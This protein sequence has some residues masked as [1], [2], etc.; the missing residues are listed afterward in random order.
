MLEPLSPATINQHFA[1]IRELVNE[2]GN[3]E[4]ISARVVSDVLRIKTTLGRFGRRGMSVNLIHRTVRGYVIDYHSPAAL[5]IYG[6]LA[7]SWG[8]HPQRF[9]KQQNF[10]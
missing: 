10:Y 4:V 1:A 8:I 3:A 5:M 7:A 6:A 9:M 2:A